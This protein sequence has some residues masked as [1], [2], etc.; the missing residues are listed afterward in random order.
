MCC[1]VGV[2]RWLI[3]VN[4]WGWID[5]EL[6]KY[7]CL[8]ENDRVERVGV[9]SHFKERRG[10]TNKA[11]EKGNSERV[12]TWHFPFFLSHSGG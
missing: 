5:D 2:K 3:P 7:Y 4:G 10:N 12:G 1:G 9:G 11:R 8:R 6:Y